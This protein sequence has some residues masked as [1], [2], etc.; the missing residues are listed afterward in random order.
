MYLLK[1]GSDE[2]LQLYDKVGSHS[3][4]IPHSFWTKKTAPGKGE[5]W[6]LSQGKEMVVFKSW[7]NKWMS[8][9]TGDGNSMSANRGAVGP[10]EKFAVEYQGGDVFAFKAWNGKYVCCNNGQ[11]MQANR[12]ALGPWEKFYVYT[13]NDKGWGVKDNGD[14]YVALKSVA[15]N[16]WVVAEGNDALN[17]NRDA[18]GPWEKWYGWTE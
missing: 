13:T 11:N 2:F 9:H 10:W 12:G 7:R 3:S 14:K 15:F 4:V 5:G 8:M 17:C 16:K 1:E 18:P 6:G